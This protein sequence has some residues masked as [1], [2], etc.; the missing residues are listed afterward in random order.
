MILKIEQN[1]VQFTIYVTKDNKI[2]KL[3]QNGK[4]PDKIIRDHLINT[5]TESLTTT[6][7]GHKFNK[8]N[9]SVNDL[10]GAIVLSTKK[11]KILGSK[12]VPVSENQKVRKGVKL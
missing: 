7:N 12:D 1:G 8:N 11:I 3:T 9:W 4:V 10:W 6:W 5:L 2:D